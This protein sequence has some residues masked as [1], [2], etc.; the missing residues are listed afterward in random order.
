MHE[1]GCHSCKNKFSA[2]DAEGLQA[3]GAKYRQPVP[4]CKVQL[5]YSMKIFKI[6]F[7]YS[8]TAHYY[9]KLQVSVLF[10]NHLVRLLPHAS[11]PSKPG[12]AETF[13][14]VVDGTKLAPVL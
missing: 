10:S 1:T 13:S 14:Q 12:T 9:I 11:K 3:S 8:C 2:G 5:L 6:V 7:R 4:A